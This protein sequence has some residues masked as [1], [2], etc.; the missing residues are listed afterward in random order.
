M[1]DERA[2]QIFFHVYWQPGRGW[3]RDP[4]ENSVGFEYA[5]RAGYMF[6]C[7][8]WSHDEVATRLLA[9]IS[10]IASQDVARAFL[11]SLATL[12]GASP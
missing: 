12:I 1:R 10:S 8:R 4:G 2:Q 3:R 9:E 6:D 11:S 5:K 7:V